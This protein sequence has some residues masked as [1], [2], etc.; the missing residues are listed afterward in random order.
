MP[1]DPVD[2]AGPRTA[3]TRD[4]LAT[5]LDENCGSLDGSLFVQVDLEAFETLDLGPLATVTGDLVVSVSDATI[6]APELS[7]APNITLQGGPI[8]LPALETAGTVNLTSD[9][10]ALPALRTAEGLILSSDPLVLEQLE[11]VGELIGPDLTVPLLTQADR[12]IADRLSAPLLTEAGTIQSAEVELP[13]LEEVELLTTFDVAGIPL[14]RSAGTLQISSSTPD[15]VQILPRLET[16]QQLQL[17]EGA[18]LVSAPVLR[19]AGAVSLQ[20]TAIDLPL[21]ETV[22]RLTLLP[23]TPTDYALP[24]LTSAGDL[25]IQGD[26]TTVD[27]PLL[28]TAESVLIAAE[29]PV[30]LGALTEADAVSVWVAATPV[31]LP[32]L[33]D[34]SFVSVHGAASLTLPVAPGWAELELVD[35]A[36]DVSLT[37]PTQMDLVRLDGLATDTVAL[38]GLADVSRLEVTNSPVL[39]TLSTP[40]L[41]TVGTL[42]LDDLPGLA[43][44]EVGLLGSITAALSV[45]QV[46]LNAA[47]LALLQAAA[48]AGGA[49]RPA[50]CP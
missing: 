20:R 2:C 45:N 6:Q 22:D 9:T 42:C 13:V 33:Q 31:A 7:A 18:G 23:D 36:D 16:V 38:T 50:S 21:L 11:A 27:I 30:Q 19:T 32:S 46:G 5:F 24:A 14:L 43:L 8:T 48:D 10:V 44:L 12:I 47:S 34:A 37:L 15:A 4:Q 25:D 3:T 28:Q 26:T 41:V 40:D 17:A 1:L 39:T 29:G 35:F 49:D